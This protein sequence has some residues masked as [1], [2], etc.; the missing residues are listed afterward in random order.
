MAKNLKPIPNDNPG[1]GKL[2]EMVRNRMGYMQDGGMV[3]DSL[4][5]MMKGGMAKKKKGYG[6]QDGGSV[7]DQL[8]N[9][10]YVELYKLFFFFYLLII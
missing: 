10:F 3:D 7:Q 4:M 2:P 9:L 5:G 1:L 6:Y 8:I